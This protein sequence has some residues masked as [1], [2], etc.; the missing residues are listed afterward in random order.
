MKEFLKE[1]VKR[2]NSSK[3]RTILKI[4]KSEMLR[5]IKIFIIDYKYLSLYMYI[6]IINFLKNF[7]YKKNVFRSIFDTIIFI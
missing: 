3:S 7:F 4:L 6:N 2:E 5:I 1:K